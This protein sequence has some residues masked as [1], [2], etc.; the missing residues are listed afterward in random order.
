MTL[1]ALIAKYK[2][3]DGCTLPASDL[4]AVAPKA[5][6]ILLQ[7]TFNRVA[8]DVSDH[9]DAIFGCFQELVDTIHQRSCGIIVSE[10]VDDW[11]QS[12]S[13]PN[14]GKTDSQVYSSIICRWLIHTDLLYRG[15]P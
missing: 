9:E 2:T 8:L 13:D 11:S 6:S 7:H 14:S 4:T 5:W 3:T 15:Y 1:D 12:Y 10:S